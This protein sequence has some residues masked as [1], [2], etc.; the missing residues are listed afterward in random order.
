VASAET[1]RWLGRGTG[2]LYR[3]VREIV[4]PLVADRPLSDDIA[5]LRSR[6]A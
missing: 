2:E 5:R 6:F 3:R 1:S 4:A